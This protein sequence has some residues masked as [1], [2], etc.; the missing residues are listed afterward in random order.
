M[1][2]GSSR[3]ISRFRVL[4]LAGTTVSRISRSKSPVTEIA[5]EKQRLVLGS[6][7]DESNSLLLSTDPFEARTAQEKP[8]VRQS[9]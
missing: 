6:Q 8:H 4:W 9:H 2:E 3:L 1:K 7:N 5:G